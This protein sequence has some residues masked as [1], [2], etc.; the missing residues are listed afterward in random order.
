MANLMK[1]GV[2][3]AALTVL[4]VLIGGALGGQNGMVMAFVALMIV[5][6]VLAFNRSLSFGVRSGFDSVC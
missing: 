3:L 5:F 6:A 1:T 4:L 2:L